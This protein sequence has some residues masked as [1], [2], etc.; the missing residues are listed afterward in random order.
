MEPKNI[1]PRL[2][3][4]G[5][6]ADA[7]IAAARSFVEQYCGWHIAPVRE[8]TVLLDGNGLKILQLPSLHVLS[9]ATVEV[10]GELLP[11][12]QYTWSVKGLLRLRHGV[13]PHEFR[14]VE[15]RFTHG[16]EDCPAIDSVVATLAE[17][18][19]MTP[20]G[21]SAMTVGGR[22]ESYGRGAGAGIAATGQEYSILDPY[23]LPLEA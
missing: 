17:R 2:A 8:D 13:W 9:V 22:S 7:C 5:D 3:N 12:N 15:V 6:A 11:E 10:D 14:S 20:A 19:L 4:G 21:I 16:F 23:R 1:S 18:A